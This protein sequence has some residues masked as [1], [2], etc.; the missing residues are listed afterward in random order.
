MQRVAGLS[1]DDVVATM[2]SL[3]DAAA[4]GRA[5]VPRLV[6]NLVRFKVEMGMI[7]ERW[8]L[9][10]LLGTILTRDTW[11]HRVADLSRATGAA[12][13]LDA[14]HDG[15]IVA[16][17]AAEWARRHGQPVELVLTGPAG[18]RFSAGIG[19]PTIEL[20]AV[21]FCRV[22]SARAE[23]THPLLETQVPF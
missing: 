19:G 17:V 10:Y 7:S 21:D 9:D 23:P 22:V 4:D 18:G 5:R 13:V 14:A 2:A 20:D 8:R 16:D 12:P 15:R 3:V 1:A 6:A 11:L